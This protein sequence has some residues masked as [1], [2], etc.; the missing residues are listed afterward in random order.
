MMEREGHTLSHTE[1]S[2]RIKIQHRPTPQ[3]MSHTYK[4]IQNEQVDMPHI[5]MKL[6]IRSHMPSV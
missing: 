4:V 5:G 2:G 6:L 1:H 3:M